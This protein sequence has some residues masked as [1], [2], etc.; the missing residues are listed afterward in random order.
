M[1]SPFFRNDTVEIVVPNK[2]SVNASLWKNEKIYSSVANGSQ[3][4]IDQAGGKRRGWSM[5]QDRTQMRRI[6]N[7]F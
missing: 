2:N 3:S 4:S 5:V 1:I 7:I 6:L